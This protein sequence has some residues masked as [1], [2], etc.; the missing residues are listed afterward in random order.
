MKRPQQTTNSELEQRETDE[1]SSF[2]KACVNGDLGTVKELLKHPKIDV[3][4][5]V[6]LLFVSI[7]DFNHL[8]CE[9]PH[10]FCFNF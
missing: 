7:F 1:Q 4:K 9:F 10:S 8:V 6:C 2:L 3:N 5:E